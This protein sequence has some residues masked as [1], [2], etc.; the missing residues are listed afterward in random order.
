[1]ELSENATKQGSLWGRE[2]RD[3]AEF[4]ERT[5]PVLWR[6]ALD[7]AGVGAGTRLLDAGCGAGGASAMA[8]GRGAIVSGCDASE[9][10]LAIARERLRG[11]D[12]KLG[13]LENLPFEDASFDAVLAINCL[14]FT[15]DPACAARELVRVAAPGGRI[16]VVVWS[17]EESEQRYIFDALR[18]LFDKPPRSRGAFELSRPGE[19]EALFPGLTMEARKIECPFVYPSLDIALR[20]QMSAGPSQ[21]VVEIFGREKTEAAMRAALQRFT[22]ASGE[23]KIQNRFHCVAILC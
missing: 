19:V 10:L 4:A 8:H 7:A 13:E 3:W 6:A 1:M 22:T 21:R 2:A 5:G 11:A 23:I 9:G 17:A 15:H 12:L 14:Q 20:G 16:V 18:G